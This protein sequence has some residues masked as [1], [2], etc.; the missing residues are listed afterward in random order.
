MLLL[1]S[2][3]ALAAEAADPV[4]GEEIVVE[5][6]ANTEA[7][8]QALEDALLSLGMVK[9]PHVGDRTVYRPLRPWKPK[10]T[11]YDWG[12]VKIR[13]RLFQPIGIGPTIMAD[14]MAPSGYPVT[15][16]TWGVK[17]T[18]SGLRTKRNM[19]SRTF[20]AIEPELEAWTTALGDEGLARRLVEVRAQVVA[21]WVDG[22]APDGSPLPT[23]EDRRAA[24]LAMWL[25]TADSDPGQRS[26]EVV[27]AYVDSVVQCSDDPFTEPE[28]RSANAARAFPRG[29][30][31]ASCR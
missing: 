25:N 15:T 17:G 9:G 24:L 27:E 5:A 6:R 18:L 22:A 11:V 23:A 20:A 12:G 19:E 2:L 14:D 28:V 1:F 13:A 30:E 4:P 3:S 26:R 10:V 7:A 31:P 8:R 21:I 16:V 29:M